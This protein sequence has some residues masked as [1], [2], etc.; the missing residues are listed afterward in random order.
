MSTF[1]NTQPKLK[2]V[3]V[4]YPESN[5]KRNWTAM[6]LREEPWEGLIGTGGGVV[7]DHGEYWNRVAYA[8]E[9]AK[10]LL[11]LRDTEPWILDYEIDIP[12]PD[13]WKGE[14]GFPERKK[15]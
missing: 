8:A 13:L 2:V 1:P 15:A 6:I 5:G 3:I 11:A 12:T 14:K 9:R 4:S 10:Y 7:I